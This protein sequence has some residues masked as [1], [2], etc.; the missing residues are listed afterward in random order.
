MVRGDNTGK[1]RAVLQIF[2]EGFFVLHIGQNRS[3][4]FCRWIDDSDLLHCIIHQLLKVGIVQVGISGR[5]TDGIRA[6]L[7]GCFLIVGYTDEIGKPNR[8]GCC[9]HQ[10]R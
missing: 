4:C 8:N 6:L 1:R 7:T 5:G 2:I 9:Q 3:D 10:H